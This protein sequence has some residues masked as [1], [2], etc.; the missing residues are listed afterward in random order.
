[1]YLTADLLEEKLKV[2]CDEL[3]VLRNLSETTI[4]NY[5]TSN[6]I[7]IKYLKEKNIILNYE[8]D[9]GDI[10]EILKKYIIY[11][12]KEEN[13][14]YST[15]NKYLQQ[16]ISFLEYLKI[17]IMIDLPKDD[18]KNK[19]IKYLKHDEIKKVLDIIPKSA[20]RDKAIIQ[21]LYRTGLRVSELANLKKHDL[22]L[23][24]Q[25]K[26]IAIDV[27]DGKGG[28]DR[29]VYI[30][31]P[32]LKLINKMIYKRT[33]KNKKDRN[34]YLFLARTGN[35]I[36]PR[37][38]EH[39]VKKYAIATDQKLAKEHIK[40][41]FEKKLTPHSLRHSFTIYLLNHAHKPIN[42]VQTLLG[43]SNIATT[44]IYSK[45]DD[46]SIKNS[47]SEINWK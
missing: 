11:L 42:E 26:A 47:Y 4:K 30:D 31:Q 32:T 3:E 8:D 25:E 40:T 46:E 2:Y 38:I 5:Y 12:R 15:I 7:F 33:R 34:D 21:T 10:S 29:R 22:N 41:N 17:K 35:V 37:S 1:M 27:E 45:I 18:S 6:H 43:H 19:K 13:N 23:N 9:D 24:S 16:I 28:K 20:I 39:L 14:K 44:Q 36:S